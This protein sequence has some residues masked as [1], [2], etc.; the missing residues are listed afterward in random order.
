[1]FVCGKGTWG[2]GGTGV[3]A[4]PL[5]KRRTAENTKQTSWNNSSKTGNQEWAGAK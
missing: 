5:A 3:G 1:V 2:G 4:L